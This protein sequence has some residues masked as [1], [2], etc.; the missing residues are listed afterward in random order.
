MFFNILMASIGVMKSDNISQLTGST[1]YLCVAA[2]F[3]T[4]SKAGENFILV[5][6]K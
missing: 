3:F 5:P 1:L 4:S 2:I 6:P